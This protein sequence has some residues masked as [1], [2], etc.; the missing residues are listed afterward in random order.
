MYIQFIPDAVIGDSNCTGYNY[1]LVNGTHGSAMFHTIFSTNIATECLVHIGYSD[2]RVTSTYDV[3]VEI[4]GLEKY[5]YNF[6]A[7]VFFGKPD[8]NKPIR[9]SE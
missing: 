8:L 6:R 5:S 7:E 4:D 3:T 2:F 9:V 1:L